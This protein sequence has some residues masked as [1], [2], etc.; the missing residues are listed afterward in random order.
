[1]PE[2]PYRDLAVHS[3]NISMPSLCHTRVTQRMHQHVHSFER[4]TVGRHYILCCCHMSRQ[5]HQS[6]MYLSKCPPHQNSAPPPPARSGCS[7]PTMEQQD[8]HHMTCCHFYRGATRA[9]CASGA[10]R[11]SSAHLIGV[12]LLRLLS[13]AVVARVQHK[14][15]H[16][17]HRLRA[18]GI[19]QRPP[20]QQQQCQS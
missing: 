9:V 12:Q 8:G 2:L 6:C 20:A 19:L 3:V 5:Q 13:A 1:M 18:Q 4:R 7:A 10:Q 11:V 17:Q 16:Q 15:C 14:Q